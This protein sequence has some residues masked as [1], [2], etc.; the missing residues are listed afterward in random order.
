MTKESKKESTLK[1]ESDIANFIQWWDRER[2]NAIGLFTSRASDY[3]SKDLQ[4]VGQAIA[5]QHQLSALSPTELEILGVLFYLQ[6][7]LGRALSG[8]TKGKIPKLDTFNDIYVYS[9]MLGWRADKAHSERTTN[10][11]D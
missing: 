6:G 3:D 1:P 4:L 5:N 9:A 8:A 10:D 2:E 7:K 11:E